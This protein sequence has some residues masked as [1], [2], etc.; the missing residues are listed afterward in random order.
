MVAD[1]LNKALAKGG[2]EFLS[3]ITMMAYN[4]TSQNG[5]IGE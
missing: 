4:T 2:Y 3:E 1:I 5:S